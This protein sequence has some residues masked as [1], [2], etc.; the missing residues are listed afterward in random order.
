MD[1]RQDV[2]TKLGIIKDHEPEEALR[3][4]YNYLD[5]W[6]D[7]LADACV[8]ISYNYTANGYTEEETDNYRKDADKL[9]GELYEK[10]E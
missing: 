10:L 3:L 6:F 4:L 9:S 7:E 5:D 2:L 1:N 8:D